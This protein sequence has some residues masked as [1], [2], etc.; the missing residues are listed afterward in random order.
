M[1]RKVLF[2]VLHRSHELHLLLLEGAVEPLVAYIP[3]AVDGHLGLALGDK[4]RVDRDV[5][6]ALALAKVVHQVARAEHVQRSQAPVLPEPTQA[7]V[8][9]A[10]GR[11]RVPF[12]GIQVQLMLTPAGSSWLP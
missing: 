7:S 2:A 6:D 4:D 3:E 9:G 10:N 12:A 5:V 1:G 11:D 8:S